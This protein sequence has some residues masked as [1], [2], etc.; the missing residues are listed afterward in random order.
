MGGK[1]RRRVASSAKRLPVP[2]LEAFGGDELA[3]QH[4]K[5]LISASAPQH[6][7]G[8]QTGQ[9]VAYGCAMA[10]IQRASEKLQRK[11]ISAKDYAMWSD[12]RRKES[13]VVA[14]LAT[15]LKITATT[16]RPKNADL[17]GAARIAPTA[18]GASRPKGT[19]MGHNPL[20]EGRGS[21]GGG[22][23]Q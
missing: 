16:D 2:K 18:P 7:T 22:L 21:S 11:R 3:Q 10:G 5:A 20:G 14:S 12:I 13:G 17:N 23:L 1:G 9:I 6:F 8:L 4:A 19:A 15:K